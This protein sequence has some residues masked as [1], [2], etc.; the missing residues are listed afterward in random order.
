MPHNSPI[1]NTQSN[2]FYVFRIVHPL[3][4]SIADL[5]ITTESHP[6]PNIS[7]YLLLPTPTAALGNY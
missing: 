5:F 6:A 7:H 2:G 1:L 3:P 4:Q